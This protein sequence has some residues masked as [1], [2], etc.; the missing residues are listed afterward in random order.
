MA[1]LTRGAY[2]KAGSSLTFKTGTWRTHRPV[3]HPM[4]AP[5]HA[6]CLAEENPQ[7]WLALLEQG[8]VER[9][10]GEIVAVNPLP[11]ITG[12]V[13]PHPC[14]TACNR[15]Q[16]DEAVCIHGGERFVG[17]Q[18]IEAGWKYE[19]PDLPASARAVAVV[20]AGP[21]GLSAAY[22]LR[23]RGYR[24]GLFEREKLAGGILRTALPAYRLPRA[25]LDAEC[26][27]LLAIGLETHF[28]TSLG[29][30]VSLRELQDDY[31]AIFLAPG[32]QRP[33]PWS[34]AGAVP[35]DLHVGVHLLNQ[36]VEFGAVPEM[37]SAAIIGGGNTAIDV[38]RVLR[39]A[40]V[41]EVHVITHRELPDPEL[42]P[43]ACMTAN[44]NEIEQ[45]LAE[46]VMIHAHHGVTR[47]ILYGGR[48]AGVEMVRMKKL[49]DE[50]G[51]LRRVP[52]EGTE[53]ILHVDQVIPAV[54]QQVEDEG[55][56]EILGGKPYLEADRWGRTAHAGI[57]T[58]GDARGGTG[59]VAASV[60][61]GRRA[62]AAMDAFLGGGEIDIREVSA[63][64]AFKHLNL[65]YYEHKP[66]APMPLLPVEKRRG[67]EEV[68]SG[69]NRDQAR[70]EAGRCFSCGQC[71]AC[72]NCWTLCPDNAVLKTEEMPADGSPYVFDYDYCKGCG[73]CASECPCGFIRMEEE[74]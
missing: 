37:K 14:E 25:V 30:D 4:P 41:E 64:I 61:D 70:D 66:R 38:A 43:H 52:F 74:T 48:V 33:R 53:E 65:H 24:V 31:A 46:G 6:T 8:D 1:I 21:A 72:D 22:H 20:G 42:P 13:C 51:Q 54:G 47:L 19:V 18:A 71:L 26:E 67:D 27:R 32:A 29:K 49:F 28:H 63:A 59:T 44:P 9:A 60:A 12:R 23:R 73:I 2:G 34:A 58:G 15:G 39:R 56:E 40:G 16:Y 50:Q 17:D 68:E 57:F 45:A 62:A 36:W 5:C 7:A 3:H 55:I 35:A 69:L 10:W 11:A